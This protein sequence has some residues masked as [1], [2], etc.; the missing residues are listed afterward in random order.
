[1]AGNAFTGIY[2]CCNLVAF[3]L[4]RQIM[5]KNI[6]HHVMETL[7]R[8][9]IAATTQRL[10]VLKILQDADQPL[11]INVI[12]EKLETKTR[13]N[14][15]TVYRI[16]SLFKEKGIVRDVSAAGGAVFFEMA[17]SDYPLHPHFSCKNCGTLSCLTPLT[18]SQVRRFLAILDNVNAEHVE[19]NLAGFCKDCRGAM[20]LSTQ[21][22]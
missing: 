22:G 20:T 18:F 6:N 2:S 9:G 15:V 7:Q 16:M 3:L 5:K 4:H 10:A 21:P 14:K 17:T 8:A 13:I 19:I 12:R 11:S 1:M